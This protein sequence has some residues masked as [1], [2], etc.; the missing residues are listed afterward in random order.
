MKKIPIIELAALLALVCPGLAQGSNPLRIRDI[1]PPV[2]TCPSN[3]VLGC[4]CTNQLIVLDFFKA[5]AVDDRDPNPTV[6]CAPPSLVSSPGV[7]P[8]VCTA[9]DS[10]GNRASCTF[11]VT[12][13]FETTPPVIQ[14]PGNISVATGSNTLAVNYSVPVTDDCST[15]VTVVCAPPS[16][17]QFPVGTTTV[18][19]AATDRCGNRSECRFTVTVKHGLM[20]LSELEPQIARQFVRGAEDFV[21]R[22]HTPAPRGMR[23]VEAR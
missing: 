2:I 7:H 3:I 18:Y 14:C 12:F 17:S 20:I 11:T 19:C 21:G 10:C 5:E 9:T 13:L 4:L 16:G 22:D 6:V 1:T 8:V 23:V 15:T